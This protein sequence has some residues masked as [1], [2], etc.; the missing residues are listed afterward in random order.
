MM[1]L[2]K[3]LFLAALLSGGTRRAYACGVDGVAAKTDT[4]ITISWNVSSCPKL[5]SGAKFEICWKKAGN[6]GA[7]CNQPTI[8]SD[9]AIGTA[10]IEGLSPSTAYKIKTQWH[11]KSSWYDVTTRIVTTNPSAISS[12]TVLRYEKG[13]SQGYAVDFYWKNRPSPPPP[14]NQDATLALL[15]KHQSIG[16]FGI[17]G[18]TAYDAQDH[19]LTNAAFNSSTNEYTKK[20][21]KFNVNRRY[22][23]YLYWRKDGQNLKRV[24]NEIEW[25]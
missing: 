20:V 5:N 25:K 18:T 9:L 1:T 11:R 4:T 3:A 16:T 12:E 13:T 23:A 17:W 2:L 14:P 24:S 8:Q 15:I 6:P 22:R 21:R 10:T 19:D 7:V